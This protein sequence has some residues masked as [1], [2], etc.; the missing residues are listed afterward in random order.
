[1]SQ[2]FRTRYGEMRA[3]DP[4]GKNSDSPAQP[5]SESF[6][7]HSNTR[8]VIFE[9]PDGRRFFLNY[10][11]LVFCDEVDKGLSILLIFTT[12]T[13]KINGLRLTGLLD[14]LASHIPKVITATNPRYNAAVA[15][16]MP[17]VNEIILVPNA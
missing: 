4:T 13:V 12:H 6:P 14:E 5:V 11:Y 7:S 1:M 17:V 8:N 3:S 16:D 9:R 2:D 10:S 15:D